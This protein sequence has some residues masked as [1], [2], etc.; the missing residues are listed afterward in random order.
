[1]NK[2][3]L[4]IYPR[5]FKAVAEGKKTFEIRKND[6][7]FF[8]GDLVVLHEYDG[9]AYTGRSILKKITYLTDYAQEDGYVVFSIADVERGVMTHV[10][11]EQL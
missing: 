5:Y 9:E 10:G 6:R 7:G 2:H 4:K 3:D 8:A 11:E 1:M